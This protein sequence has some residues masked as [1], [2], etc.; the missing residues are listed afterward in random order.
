VLTGKDPQA[1]SPLLT[2]PKSLVMDLPALPL[3]MPSDLLRNRPDVRRAERQLAAATARIGVAVADWFP[4][5]SL[6][7]S[8][9]FQAT[10]AKNLFNDSSN[11]W[12][13]GP[14]VSWPIFDAGRI[15]SNIHV[16]NARQEQALALYEN[17]VLTA[18]QDVEDSLVAYDREQA[19]RVALAQSV[20]SNRRAVDL[21]TQ[22]YS[23]GLVDF[24]SVLDAQRELFTA[25]DLLVRSDTFVTE[26][27]IAVYKALGGGWDQASPNAVANAAPMTTHN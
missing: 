16:Q 12:S 17:T 25:E 5:F 22:L 13:V 26:D 9:A 15:T 19:R 10:Q 21:A 7:G 23:R 14:S 1:L 20:A 2:P 11:L 8:Y 27:L 4:R 3:G 18:L 6:T 24:L